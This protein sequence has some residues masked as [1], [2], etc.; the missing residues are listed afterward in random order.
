MSEVKAYS[1]KELAALYN[2]SYKTIRVW[3]KPFKSELG[4]YTGK[5]FTIAQ[6]QLIFNKIGNP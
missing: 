1:Y 6:V 5:R 4:N 2:V 3:I